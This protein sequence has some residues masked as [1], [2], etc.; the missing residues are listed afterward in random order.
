M[1][2]RRMKETLR[3]QRRV[4]RERDVMKASVEPRTCNQKSRN[5][6]CCPP[7]SLRPVLENIKGVKRK[8][9]CVLEVF[10]VDFPGP[11][12]RLLSR[13]ALI[14][15][16]VT[17]TLHSHPLNSPPPSHLHLHSSSSIVIIITSRPHSYHVYVPVYRP[18]SSRID[19][20]PQS[21]RD[22]NSLGFK[23]STA[24]VKF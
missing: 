15:L 20:N 13:K 23:S 21:T 16:W 14:R 11:A 5:A 22:G 3:W 6:A 8:G 12:Q 18:S 2:K 7:L 19:K 17:A 10:N 24:Y 4:V 1:P 9:S